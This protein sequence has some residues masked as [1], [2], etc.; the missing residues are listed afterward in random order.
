MKQSIIG[1]VLGCVLVGAILGVYASGLKTELNIAQTDIQ[2]QKEYAKKIEQGK[3]QTEQA[4]LQQVAQQR[5][6]C[7]SKFQRATFLYETA[8]LGGPTRLWAIPADIEPVYLGAKH[9]SFS[10]YD[11][12]LQTETVQFQAK[13]KQ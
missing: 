10:H 5:D 12:K 2:L 6:A 11:S 7:Q 3:S 9:G 8:F 4:E 1:F 13:A